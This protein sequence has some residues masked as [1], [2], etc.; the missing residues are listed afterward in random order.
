MSSD[1][2]NPTVKKLSAGRTEF[3]VSFSAE[4]IAPAEEAALMKLGK[5]IKI[6]GFREGEAPADMIREKVNADALFEETVRELLP[7]TF[8]KLVKE[9]DLKPILHPKVEA[10]SRD[11]ICLKITFVEKPEVKVKGVDKIKIEKK[12]TKVDDKDVAKMMDYLMDQHKKTEPVDR[13]AKEGD[14]ITMSFS[15]K[16]E[17]GEDIPEI[18]TDNHQVVIGSKVLIPGFEDELTGMKKDETKSFTLT[19]PDKYHA[20]KLQG[21]PVTFSATVTQVEEVT[22][23]KLTDEFVKESFGVDTADEFKKQMRERMEQEE[24]QIEQE[25]RKQKLLDAIA[26]ATT[27]E[28]APELVEEETKDLLKNF[29]QQLQSQGITFEQWM[30]HSKKKPDEVLEDMKKQAEQRLKTRLGIEKVVV[31]KDVQVEDK[32]VD[33]MLQ[34]MLATVPPDKK[35]EVESYYSKGQ[36]GYDQLKWQLRVEKVIDMLLAD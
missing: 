36:S 9:N 18:K 35:K 23:P 13:A 14:R 20:E 28:L 2:K 5:N 17:K 32:D 10:E 31:D 27:V 21:K 25:G 29:E 26:E 8:D 3:T 1:D 33:K 11:P 12:D 19:F 4:E 16:D 22:L 30:Q 7:S 24:N 6:D 34:S 15:G